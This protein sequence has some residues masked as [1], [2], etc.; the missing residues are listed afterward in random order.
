MCVGRKGFRVP[1]KPF[2][3]L[4]T[5][6]LFKVIPIYH[7]TKKCLKKSNFSPHRLE[8]TKVKLYLTRCKNITFTKAVKN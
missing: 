3:A 7:F 2:S 8:A 4:L 1:L 5:H 6:Y